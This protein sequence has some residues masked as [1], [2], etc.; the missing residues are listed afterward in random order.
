MACL[1][2]MY[3]NEVGGA[4]SDGKTGFLHLYVQVSERTGFCESLAAGIEQRSMRKPR[5]LPLRHSRLLRPTSLP[6]LIHS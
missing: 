6:L 1:L 5:P 2:L 4:D 3:R